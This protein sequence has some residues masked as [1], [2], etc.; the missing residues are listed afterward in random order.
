M[1]NLSVFDTYADA[2][3][4]ALRSFR[5]DR[6]KRKDPYLLALNEIVNIDNLRKESLGEIDVPSEL[7]IGTL[8]S[9]RKI[10]FSKDFMPLLKSN[11][12]FADKWMK[13]VKYHLSDSGINEA[14]SAIEYLGKFYIVEGNK[15]VSVLK[16]FGAAYI[17]L[18]VNRII[19]NDN[20]IYNE[21][22]DYYKK[23]KLYSI[24]FN[25][26]GYYDKLLRLIGFDVDYEFTRIDRYNL[27]G[28]YER[29]S[30]I[31]KHY[32]LNTSFSDALLVLIEIYGYKE[33]LNMKDKELKRSI[34][35]S[36]IKLKYDKAYYNILCVADEEDN[37]IYHKTNF[38]DIDFIISAGDLKKE[39]LEYLV[40][41]INKPLLYVF[42][43]HDD[44]L[45]EAPPEGCI[46]I[47]DNVYELNGIRILGLGGSFKYRGNSKH[48]Y[49]EYE[50]VKRIKKLKR[51]IKKYNGI[52]IIVAH[53]PIK[54][55][56]DLNDYA[57]QGFDCFKELINEYNP[58]YFIF[59]HVHKNYEYNYKGFYIYKNTQVI[60]VSL[61]QNIIF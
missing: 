46:N 42:G 36:F 55:I 6:F 4:R 33:L 11:S 18:N 38:D 51:K 49:S 30:S 39:Y 7:I 1:N 24:Q 35:E 58:K 13:V 29:V 26:L 50:M 37:S 41:I 47:D 27:V 43:N 53:S 31:L 20:Q 48:M 40:T 32:D 14:P 44:K 59:A 9:S 52:D 10:S 28:L 34:D 16:Y 60:N 15:R 3:K 19:V 54:G 25:K 61:K 17:T 21:F 56:G 57:H 2:N 23:S 45:D 5:K 12:E 8:N 22:L